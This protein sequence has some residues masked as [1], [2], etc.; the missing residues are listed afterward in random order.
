MGLRLGACVRKDSTSEIQPSTLRLFSV[1]RYVVI[2]LPGKLWRAIFDQE[3]LAKW[4]IP[5]SLNVH[6]ARFL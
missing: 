1:I 5:L 3:L 2:E 6:S 4:C